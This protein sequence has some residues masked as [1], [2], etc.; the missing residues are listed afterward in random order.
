MTYLGQSQED[1]IARSQ[2]VFPCFTFELEIGF[3]RPEKRLNRGSCLALKSYQTFESE[4]SLNKSS[5][6]LSSES[7]LW[8]SFRFFYFL[9]ELDAKIRS[10]S[11]RLAISSSICRMSLSLATLKFRSSSPLLKK[12]K[13]SGS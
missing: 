5:T 7:R 3:Y 9:N 12:F 13:L 10:S 4:E 1:L 11:L 2:S 8:C 6:S